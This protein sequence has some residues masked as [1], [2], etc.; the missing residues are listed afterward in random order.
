VLAFG[1][2]NSSASSETDSDM[3]DCEDDAQN[4]PVGLQVICPRLQEEC[5]LALATI[6]EQALHARA[7]SAHN[8]D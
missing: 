7:H 6:I 3:A 1:T 5:A 2:Q 4:M 8:K